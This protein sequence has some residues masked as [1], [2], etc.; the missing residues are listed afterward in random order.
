MLLFV[1][2]AVC[3]AWMHVAILRMEQAR[4]VAEMTSPA[5]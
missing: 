4:A 3:F 1:V 5:E 2:V